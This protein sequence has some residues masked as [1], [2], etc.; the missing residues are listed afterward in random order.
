MTAAAQ[1]GRSAVV[2][3]DECSERAACRRTPP[4]LANRSG[5]YGWLTPELGPIHRDFALSDFR[6]LL[7][8]ARRGDVLVQAALTVAETEFLLDV[9]GGSNGLVRGVVGWVDLAA[10]DAVT[11]L[12]MVARDTYSSRSVR[13]CRTSPIRSGF[14]GAMSA[15]HW[16]RCRGLAC[17]SM[18]W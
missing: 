14:Y 3:D 6:P 18:R 1:P 8:R 17:G 13:C 2:Q 15:L 16:P 4:R 5:D 10:P 7:G 12:L 9:A 11:T